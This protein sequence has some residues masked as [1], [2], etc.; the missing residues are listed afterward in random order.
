[1]I[2]RFHKFA[3]VAGFGLAM[4]FTFSCS[5]DDGG[6]NPPPISSSGASS[7]SSNIELYK[8]GNE[9]YNPETQF[10][11]DNATN[12]TKAVKELCGTL[13]YGSNQICD[14]NVVKTECIMG[15]NSK[16]YLYLTQF[17]T[18]DIVYERCNGQSYIPESQKCE[19]GVIWT[20]CGNSWNNPT[21]LQYCKN[22]TT[23]TPYGS[24]GYE[25]KTYKTVEI[26]TQTW[27]AENLNHKVS[28][29]RCYGDNTGG[30]SQDN[31]IKYG[32][33][34]N[35]STA[36][37]ICPPGWHLPRI[38]EWDVLMTAV[39]GSSTAGTKLKSVSGWAED[40][41]NGRASGNGTDEFGFAAL[42]GGYIKPDGTDDYSI[43]G[44]GGWWSDSEL[45][46]DNARLMSLGS[47]LKH[48]IYNDNPKTILRSVRCLKDSP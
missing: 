24:F 9:L 37:G 43:D 26:G 12:T 19:N 32:R 3:V 21:T 40:G 8:C 28:N 16:Y 31:C 15:S 46:A 14:N 25:G 2:T 13:E 45:G 42:P 36:R 7:S 18:N 30:D 20:K 34:Y 4:A 27:M 38:D 17:C 33:L 22:G 10:C 5:S 48:A 44:Y 23:L 6:D 39:G 41:F 1:M 47:I 11:Q 29:S 35:W